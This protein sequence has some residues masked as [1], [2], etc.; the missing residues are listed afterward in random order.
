MS[1]A[2]PFDAVVALGTTVVDDVVRARA[3]VTAR[4]AICLACGEDDRALLRSVHR[5][6]QRPLWDLP[7]ARLVQLGASNQR[8]REELAKCDTLCPRC[9]LARLN[10]QSCRIAQLGN[11]PRS[12]F[13]RPQMLRCRIDRF[14]WTSGESANHH[15]WGAKACGGALTRNVGRSL[16]G[17][18]MF[19]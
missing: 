2:L 9:H 3:Y 6:P 10:T 12:P 14:H 19:T 8:L 1:G 18:G 16:N 15:R 17:N 7:V 4:R 5:Q 11:V 13:P